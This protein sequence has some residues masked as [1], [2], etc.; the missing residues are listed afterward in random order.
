MRE[1][2]F[3]KIKEKAEEFYKSINSIFCPYFNENVNFNAKG[4]DHIKFKKWNKPR[5][6]SDQCMRLRFIEYAPKV[7]NKSHTLQGYSKKKEF[8]RVKRNT[9][10][11]L[12][13]IDVEYYE[14]ISVLDDVRIKVI[15]KY[16]PGGSK[17]FWSIIPFWKTDNINMERLLY[18]GKPDED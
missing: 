2:G 6:T 11:D 7:I 13:L 4:L 16:V 9:R 14:F 8:E 3:I 5:T 17:Y 15:V 18:N 1:E 10:W 12:V